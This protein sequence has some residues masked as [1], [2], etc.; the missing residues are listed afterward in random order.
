MVAI[1]FCRNGIS[2]IVLFIYTPWIEHLGIKNT[3]LL[4]AFLALAV[5]LAAPIIFLFLGKRIRQATASAFRH[6]AGLQ[7]RV[8]S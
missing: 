6:Y 5:L 1:V 3:Y 8:R 2:L 4:V 7:A